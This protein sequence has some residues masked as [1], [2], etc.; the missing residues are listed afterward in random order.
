MNSN[1]HNKLRF[2]LLVGAMNATPQRPMTRASTPS[3]P[4]RMTTRL[5]A[6]YEQ[7]KTTFFDYYNISIIVYLLHLI[8]LT[9]KRFMML[10]SFNC[11][12]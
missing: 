10:K 2:S 1:V 9:V 12:A 11:I 6:P 3:A 8:K 7:G 4:Q 5:A